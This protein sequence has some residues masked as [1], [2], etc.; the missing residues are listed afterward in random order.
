MY[1]DSFIVYDY[2]SCKDVLRLVRQCLINFIMV[3]S[4]MI[5]LQLWKNVSAIVLCSKKNYDLSIAGEYVCSLI[6][7]RQIS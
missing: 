5:I 2:F 7:A 6:I 3:S 4:V 1:L